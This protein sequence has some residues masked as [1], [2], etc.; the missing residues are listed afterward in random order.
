[1]I[2]GLQAIFGGESIGPDLLNEIKAKG[3]QLIR[4][5]VQEMEDPRPLIEEIH[6]A[7]LEAL[8][9]I[10]N[11]LVLDLLDPGM[12]VELGNEPDLA[13]EGWTRDTY[14]ASVD[15]AMTISAGRHKLFIGCPSNLNHR[16]L[17]W[18]R[19]LPWADFPSWVGCSVHR[20]PVG[21]YGPW[22]GHKKVPAWWKWSEDAWPGNRRMTREEEVAEVR[23][24]VGDRPL[25]LTEFG[26]SGAEWDE[27]QQEM[28]VSWERAF[29]EREGFELGVAYQLNSSATDP[30]GYRRTDGSWKPMTEAWTA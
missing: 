26:Y 16:G 10:R 28:F 9:I 15:S 6:A 7:G 20:Y 21:G 5:D 24:I 27:N 30:Y 23:A 29:W 17:T 3:F 13:H 19:S 18:L 22:T 4:A 12:R 2:K 1:M 14:L 25:A 8:P 11:P